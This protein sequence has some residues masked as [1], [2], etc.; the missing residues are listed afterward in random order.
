MKR[1]GRCLGFTAEPQGQRE[2]AE[3]AFRDLGFGDWA[4]KGADLKPYTAKEGQYLAYIAQFT[5]LNRMVPSE[6]EMQ[7][8]FQVTPPSVHQM[9]LTLETR[10]YISRVPG[11]A[12][13]IRLVISEKELPD[14]E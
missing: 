2:S 5:K 4:A 9:V 10:G 7:R 14:L 13:S 3:N 8:Y 6:V 12:R 11:Q 1:E